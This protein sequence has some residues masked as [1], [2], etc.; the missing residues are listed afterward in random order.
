M[1]IQ[2]I[3][4]GGQAGADRAALDAAIEF[5]VPHGAWVHRGRK[6]EDSRLPNTYRMKQTAC[7]T[8]RKNDV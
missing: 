6:T 3:I 8:H 7:I 2:K 1:Q 5:A 4:S